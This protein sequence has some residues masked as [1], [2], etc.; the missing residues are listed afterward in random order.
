MQI[1]AIVFKGL[2]GGI[3]VYRVKTAV[4]RAVIVW[5]RQAADVDPQTD[6]VEARC[7][8][9]VDDLRVVPIVT[10]AR[11]G[12]IE[13]TGVVG[14]HADERDRMI[15]RVDEIVRARPTLTGDEEER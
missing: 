5:A 1:A 10:L 3:V 13:V 8:S 12:L 4:G 11:A 2:I 15:G 6:D 14:R 9:V 7:H